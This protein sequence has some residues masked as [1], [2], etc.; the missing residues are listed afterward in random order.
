MIIIHQAAEKI[1]ASMLTHY[2]R[3]VFENSEVESVEAL[4]EWVIQETEFQNKALE[5]VH[6]LTIKET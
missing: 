1:P 6:S 3:W 4:R 2:H 5:T